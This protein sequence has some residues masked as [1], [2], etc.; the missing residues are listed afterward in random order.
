MKFDKIIFYLEQRAQHHLCL[1]LLNEIKDTKILNG[2]ITLD[3]ALN[4]KSRRFTLLGAATSGDFIELIKE[5]ISLNANVNVLDIHRYSPL[6]WSC[7]RNNIPI[8]QLIVKNGADINFIMSQNN[9]TLF[10]LS[11]ETLIKLAINFEKLINL[12]DNGG[13]TVVSTLCDMVEL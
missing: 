6:A 13:H 7:Y 4:T 1:E 3:W 11:M 9:N 12:Q 10:H 5:L 2:K 8:I